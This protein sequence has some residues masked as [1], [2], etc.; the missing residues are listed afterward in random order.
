MAKKAKQSVKL[1]KGKKLEKT[2]P[3]TKVH[4]MPITKNYDKPSASL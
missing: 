1:H 2:K 4:D 3:L